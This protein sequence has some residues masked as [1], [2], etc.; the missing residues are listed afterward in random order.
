MTRDELDEQ[1][2]WEA[3]QYIPFDVNEVNLDFQILDSGA[4]GE[5][6]ARWT[7]CSSRPRRT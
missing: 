2:R 6:T 1:I 7:C 3:E 5:A 4:A